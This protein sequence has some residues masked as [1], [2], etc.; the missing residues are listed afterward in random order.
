MAMLR[1]GC[2]CGRVRYE[3]HGTPFHQTI[4]HCVDCRRVAGAPCV[5]WFS[6]RTA[7]LRFVAGEPRRYASSARAERGFC[8]DC[9]TPLTFQDHG[10][11]DEIDVTT[12][13]LDEPE[14][15]PPEDHVRAARKLPWIHL[16][17]GLPRYPGTRTEGMAGTAPPATPSAPSNEGSAP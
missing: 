6:V 5:A 15:M 3:A 16:A 9:G 7:D 10:L 8:G 14:R 11:P 4:C 1:G 17:D 12:C 2:H 13:S